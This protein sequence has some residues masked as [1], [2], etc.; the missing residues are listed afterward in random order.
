MNDQ[1]AISRALALAGGILPVSVVDSHGHPAVRK[2][3]KKLAERTAMTDSAI[4]ALIKRYAA[5]DVRGELFDPG[6]KGLRIRPVKDGRSG[7]WSLQL[8]DQAGELTRFNLGEYPAIGIAEARRLAERTRHQVR[9]EG[10]DPNQIRQDKRAAAQKEEEKLDPSYTLTGILDEY[11]RQVGNGQKNWPEAKSKIKLVFK[12]FLDVDARLLNCDEVQIA[13]DKYKSPGS[14]SSAVRYLK[15]VIKWAAK[16]KYA[17][18]DIYLIEQPRKTVARERYLDRDELIRL[19]P[20]LRDLKH[21]KRRNMHASA[22]LF[23]LYTATRREESAGAKWGEIKDGIWTIPASRIKA[24][25]GS[26]KK[27]HIVPLSTQAIALLESIKP[28]KP[29]KSEVDDDNDDVKAAEKLKDQLIFKNRFGNKL[30][31][32]DN[33][34]KHIQGLAGVTGWHR[35]D[36][37]RTA[38]TT[39]GNLKVPPYV[40]EA[41]LNHAEIHSEL[42]GVYNQSR[43]TVEVG[44]AFQVLGDYFDEIEKEA[45]EKLTKNLANNAKK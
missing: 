45:E 13:A 3:R 33:R 42:A 36:L 30:G 16:R 2:P 32:W 9:Q 38:A 22:M 12:R 27:P 11:E 40:I 41:S 8:R 25:P 4:K 19:L 20:V 10:L 24:K 43:Y 23:I 37:R 35:H 39:M 6:S 7:V 17:N 29:E 15:P 1:T 26:K 44:G 34:T 21:G 28:I 14:A 31:N 18:G 5:D